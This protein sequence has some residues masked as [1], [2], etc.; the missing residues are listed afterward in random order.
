MGLLESFLAAG[1]QPYHANVSVWGDAHPFATDFIRG[2]DGHGWHI[3]RAAFEEGLRRAIRERGAVVLA[4][5]RLESIAATRSGWSLGVETPKGPR[6]LH[7]RVVIDATGRRASL[8]RRLGASTCGF[9]RLL[10]GWV[11]G[12][13][14]PGSERGLTYVES[15]PDG[16]WYTAPIPGNR[17]VLAFHTDAD[18][19]SAATACT[20]DLLVERASRLDLIGSALE[21]CHFERT[22]IFGVTA[23]GTTRRSPCAG[24]GWMAAGDAALALDP[25]SSQGLVN[26]LFTGL[27]AAES[28]DRYLDGADDAVH[29]YATTV[30]RVFAAYLRQLDHWYGVERRWPD[31]PFWRRRQREPA[32]RSLAHPGYSREVGAQAESAEA[33][34][35]GSTEV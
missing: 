35:N 23:A 10:C 17:R 6:T 29:D 8:A 19:P 2:P 32:V 3:D 5:A 15:A 1:H 7:A 21:A 34:T 27:A 20:P 28:A 22:S 16:W 14:A 30:D 33:G 12:A 4:P 11:H 9:D 31:A 13:A 18:L 25:L 24:P 26:A